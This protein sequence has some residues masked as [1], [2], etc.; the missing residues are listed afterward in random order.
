VE[1]QLKFD[2]Y[3]A[4]AFKAAGTT[5]LRWRNNNDFSIRYSDIVMGLA[6]LP[7]ETVIDDEVIA[8]AD[9]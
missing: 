5:H 3:R 8:L 7:D 2:G 1:I 9:D 4:I 6:K